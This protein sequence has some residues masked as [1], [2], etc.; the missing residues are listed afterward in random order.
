METSASQA[1]D[2]RSSPIV[3]GNQ[4]LPGSY[5]LHISIILILQDCNVSIAIKET[6]AAMD[7]IWALFAVLYI[8]N[9]IDPDQLEN[10]LATY[11]F[12]HH[13]GLDNFCLDGKH[14]SPEL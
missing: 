10:F 11:G 4:P 14:Y 13:R 1:I 9:L 12:R 6:W 2:T 5:W 7:S 8:E 3:D